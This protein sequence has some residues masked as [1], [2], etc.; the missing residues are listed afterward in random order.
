MFT[1]S[2]LSQAE[3]YDEGVYSEHESLADYLR[4]EVHI[5]NDG[6]TTLIQA[7]LMLVLFILRSF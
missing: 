6:Q 2:Q 3:S 1:F 5:N 7:N 4:K